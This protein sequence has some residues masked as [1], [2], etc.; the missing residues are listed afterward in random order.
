MIQVKDPSTGTIERLEESPPAPQLKDLLETYVLQ[1]NEALAT[2]RWMQEQ[3]LLSLAQ[4]RAWDRLLEGLQRVCRALDAGFDP[5]APPDWGHGNIASY[6]APIPQSVREAI[7][8]AIPIFGLPTIEVYD[9]NP[10]HFVKPRK[11]DPLVLGH[12]DVAEQRLHF[13]IGQWD[14]PTDMKF[15]EGHPRPEPNQQHLTEI[16]RALDT[17][18]R[19]RP[20]ANPSAEW[21]S[22]WGARTVRKVHQPQWVSTMYSSLGVA[23]ISPNWQA[24]L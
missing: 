3:K 16:A 18:R 13:L 24:G 19:V 12:V 10:A 21:E 6:M 9:P 23:T 22:P 11:L 17:I 2:Y 4:G 15:I 20:S 14:I 5:W 8:R 7:Q 1:H